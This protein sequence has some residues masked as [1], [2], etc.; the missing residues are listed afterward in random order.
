MPVLAKGSPV[1]L[2]P[3][4]HSMPGLEAAGGHV[5]SLVRTAAMQQQVVQEL[6]LLAKKNDA[7][8]LTEL[9]K[10]G[11]DPNSSN[12][13]GQA[14]LMVCAIWG[15]VD[16]ATVLL[17]CGAD[18]NVQN[19]FG[20][21]PLH[22]AVEK[23]K[24]PMIELLLA[25][26]ASINIRAGNGKAAYDMVA[27]EES[28]LRALLGAPSNALHRAVE[29]R[30]VAAIASM[31]ADAGENVSDVDSANNTALHLAVAVAVKELESYTSESDAIGLLMVRS[32]R[33]VIF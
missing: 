24:R 31:L 23:K 15:C 32:S 14:P 21:T 17:D 18:P 3:G 7:E 4:G 9:L 29:A 28:E 11:A 33:V 6:L 22:Y 26:G 25:K 27:P 13:I 16:A 20:V 10:A 8:R 5:A 1:P 2:A 12:A 19:Q 30:D